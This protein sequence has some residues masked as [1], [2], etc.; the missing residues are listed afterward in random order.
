MKNIFIDIW[1]VTEKQ[2]DPMSA[3]DFVS[4]KQNGADTLFVG[5]VRDLNHNKKVLGITYDVFVPAARQS[6]Q[7]ICSRAKEKW[8]EDLCLYIV[9][10]KGRLS[11][12]GISTV[13]AVG[14]PHR[15]EAFQVCRYI[16]EEI[17]KRSP[18]WKLEHY[19]DGESDW[20][21]GCELCTSH[22]PSQSERIS[23]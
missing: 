5:T 20:T 14:A 4:Q 8:G 9:H 3:L 13:I 21:K 1:D 16:I 2:L 10:A 15:D 22:P 19:K 12:Q 17:K 7:D 11:V 18:I 6:F 23:A